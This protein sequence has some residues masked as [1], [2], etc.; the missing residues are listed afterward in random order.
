M[1]GGEEVSSFLAIQRP[2]LRKFYDALA[3]M[4]KAKGKKYLTVQ[5]FIICLVF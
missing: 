2:D 3:L 1:C 4:F 5:K